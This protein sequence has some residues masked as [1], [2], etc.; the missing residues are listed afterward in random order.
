VERFIAWNEPN[1]AEFLRPQYDPKNNLENVSARAYMEILRSIRDG[2]TGGG[3]AQAASPGARFRPA[4]LSAGALTGSGK[5]GD[6]SSASTVRPTVFVRIYRQEAVLEENAPLAM[7]A[8][9]VAAWAQ[10]VYPYRSP[11]PGSKVKEVCGDV[12]FDIFAD[13]FYI[14]PQSG[15][16]TRRDKSLAGVINMLDDKESDWLSGLPIWL[17]ETGV[18]TAPPDFAAGDPG[19][20]AQQCAA[21]APSGSAAMLWLDK[22]D[23]HIRELKGRFTEW[24]YYFLQDNAD[25]KSGLR[26]TNGAPKPTGCRLQWLWGGRGYWE[27]AADASQC[28]R[29]HA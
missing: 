8:G 12:Y 11:E 3:R 7:R 9:E 5:G 16:R 6:S 4:M 27:A 26:S 22:M 23:S 1:S 10:H 28:T 18:P 2:L 19:A 14:D 15:A 24:G 29:P 21:V 20:E 17:T 13:N 25:W